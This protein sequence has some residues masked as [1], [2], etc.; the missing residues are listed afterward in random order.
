MA[1]DPKYLVDAVMNALTSPVPKQKY[2]VKN[3]PI[4]GFVE[5]MHPLI[6]D[7]AY[8][9]ILSSKKV[10]DLIDKVKDKFDK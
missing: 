9:K 4:L 3:S 8:K 1:N 5:I 6:V 10:G 7:S 2:R